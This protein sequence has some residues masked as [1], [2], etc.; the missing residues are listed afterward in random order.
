MPC[1]WSLRNC[2]RSDITD[3]DSLYRVDPSAIET[4]LD[5]DKAELGSSTSSTIDG[6]SDLLQLIEQHKP[7]F[8]R[9]D[10]HIKR[11]SLT[12]TDVYVL[13][14]RQLPLFRGDPKTQA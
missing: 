1:S 8:N 7:R 6:A 10:P 2:T 5:L 12:L 11:G 13:N 4:N 14:L 9:V 3:S